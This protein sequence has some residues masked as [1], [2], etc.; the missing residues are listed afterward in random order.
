MHREWFAVSKQETC[1][2]PHFVDWA[3]WEHG[4]VHERNVC[5]DQVRAITILSLLAA[6]YLHCYSL[7]EIMLRDP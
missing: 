3:V 4:C 5:L 7:Q 6:K 2:K 1:E